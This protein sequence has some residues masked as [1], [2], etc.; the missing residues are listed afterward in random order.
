[1]ALR[2][3]VWIKAGTE[4]GW[5]EYNYGMMF[6]GCKYCVLKHPSQQKHI[7]WI[8][9]T[10]YI[11]VVHQQLCNLVQIYNKQYHQLRHKNTF[12]PPY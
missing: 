11:T 3:K 4:N 2:P 7:I 10:E 1:M 8:F 6:Q 12:S 9:V 5:M